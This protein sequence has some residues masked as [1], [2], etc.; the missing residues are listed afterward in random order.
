MIKGNILAAT[1]RGS[2]HPKRNRN[3]RK[4]KGGGQSKGMGAISPLYEKRLCDCVRTKRLREGG[5]G[6][7]G[8]PGKFNPRGLDLTPV[9]PVMRKK[10]VEDVT[11]HIGR[12]RAI[13]S[14]WGNR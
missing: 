10:G 11:L 2:S 7:K 5:E 9:R 13:S 8:E 4:V 6:V 12:Q 14:P 1:Q 3:R